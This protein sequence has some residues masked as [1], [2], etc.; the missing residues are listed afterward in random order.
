MSTF[1]SVTFVLIRVLSYSSLVCF[2][3]CHLRGVP[4]RHRHHQLE[5]WSRKRFDCIGLSQRVARVAA[6]SLNLVHP[7]HNEQRATTKGGEKLGMGPRS[8]CCVV[9]KEN[10]S[11]KTGTMEHTHFERARI[12]AHT[13]GTHLQH[14]WP[15]T[16]PFAAVSPWLSGSVFLYVTPCL[17]AS[18]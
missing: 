4:Q 9:S 2:F 12:K 11:H 7:R 16:G 17:R 3:C 13:R 14:R 1:C 8:F 10:I 6:N 5:A 15:S 18:H